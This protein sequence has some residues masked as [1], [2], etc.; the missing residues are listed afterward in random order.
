[1]TVAWSLRAGEQTV[2]LPARGGG[3]T[4]YTLD[5]AGAV[6]SRRVSPSGGGYAV[7]LPGITNHNGLGGRPILRGSP[8]MLVEGG[9][10]AGAL[11]PPPSGGVAQPAVPGGGASPAPSGASPP[12]APRISGQPAAPSAPDPARIA[13]DTSPPVLA[14]VR[15]IPA[16]SPPRIEVSVI[17][18][19]E[20]SGVTAFSVY[21]ARGLRPPRPEEWQPVIQELPW[22]ADPRAGVVSFPWEGKPGEVWYFAA[23]ARDAA[24]NWTAAPTLPHAATRFAMPATPSRT[25]PVGRNIAR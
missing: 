23:Q 15:E 22:T 3:A 8:V 2:A 18:G 4:L 7:S 24:G 12:S 13:A 11:A 1:M 9:A 20:E 17:A 25:R 19:D 10:T 5:A 6:T 14:M 16:I 21:V